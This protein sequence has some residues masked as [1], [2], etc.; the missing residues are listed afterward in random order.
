MRELG[1]DSF[2]FSVAWPRVLPGR[3]RPRQRSGAG[4][5]RPARRRAARERDRTRASR[6]ITGTSRSALEDAGGW[7]EPRD[8]RGVRRVRGG[9]RLAARRPRHALDHAQRAV[10][11]VLARL[12]LGR[13]RARTDERRRRGRGRAPPAP[14]ARLGGRGAAPRGAR[15]RGRDHA[16]PHPRP[17]RRATPTPTPTRPRQVDAHMNRWFLDPLFRGEYPDDLPYAPPVHAGRPRGDRGAARLPRRELLLPRPRRGGARR[18]AA[19]PPSRTSRARPTPTW[20]GRSTRTASTQCLARVARDYAPPAIY[21]TENGAAFGDVRLHDGSVS[22]P[23]RRDYLAGHL[24]RGR[25]R[26]RRRRAGARLLRL[27]AARQLRVGARLREAVRD[28]LRRLPDARARAEGEL[29]LVPRLRRGARERKGRH[30]ARRP[31][32]LHRARRVRARLPNRRCARWRRS[33]SRASSSST[34]TATSPAEVARVLDD[35][36]LVA[37]GRHASL[38]AIESELPELAAEAAELGWRRLVVSWVD[39]VRAR[40]GRSRPRSR[41]PPRQPPRLRARARLPQ[42]RCGGEAA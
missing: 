29:L 10:G 26:D 5:L 17:S 35:T 40:P 31:D 9:R 15:G 18:R 8:R 6:C 38:E 28:R 24:G 27:V 1:L 20:A 13:P 11:R 39:P 25:A 41:T 14:L 34:C 36:G 21:V 23:E 4:L 7:P 16:E 37:C 42:P 33:A 19:S 22:D 30:G 32:A 3:A 2:R 12:R